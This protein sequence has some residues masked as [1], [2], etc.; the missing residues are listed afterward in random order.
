MQRAL[1][2]T[3]TFFALVFL[4]ASI[5][6]RPPAPVPADAPA[7]RFSATLAREM[8]TRLVGDGATRYV[9]TPGN[10]RGRAV[11]VAQL[12]DL[13]WKVEVQEA[14]SCTYHGNCAP[15]TNVVAQ[16]TGREPSLPGVLLTA[17]Y[18][19]VPTSPGA[20]DD[21]FGTAALL[22]TA[23][24]LAAGPRPRRTIV[25]A[26][27][28]GEEA[29]LLGAEAFTRGHPLAHT[30]GATVN[31]D[32]RGSG[33]PSQVFE[34]SPGNAWLVSLMSAHIDRPVTSSLFYEV[35]K[36]MPNDTDFSLTKTLA[37]GLNFANVRGIENYHTP[38]DA[39]DSSDIG[40][41]QHHGDQ[42]LAMT[43][44]FVD[45]DLRDAAAGASG[46]AVWFDVLAL[47]IVRWPE[48]WSIVLALVGLMLV[49]GHAIRQR[50]FDRGL[51]VFFA[52]IV[53][54][55]L[56]P[57][58]VRLGLG[59]VGAVPAP[60]IA[61]PLPA[62]VALHTSAAAA[63]LGVGY[64]VARR[65][66][67]Q[68]VWAGTWIGWGLLGVVA[69]AFAPGT[70]YVFVVPTLIAGLGAAL[71]LAIA[72]VAPAMAAS[73]VL[74]F[75]LVIYDALGLTFA[76]LLVL[77]TL[78]LC[79]TLAP[80]VVDLLKR[81][82]TRVLAALGAVALSLGV[83]AILVPKF[84]AA[85]PQR[86]NV[87]FRQDDRTARVFLDNTWKR[88]TWGRPPAPMVD[89]IGG[90]MQTASALPWTLPSRFA[91]APR[92]ELKAPTADVL[93]VE[94]DGRRH[95]VRIRVRSPRGA[96]TLA[97][98]FPHGRDVAVTVAGRRADLRP[99]ESGRSVGLLAVPGEGVLVE[100]ESPVGGPIA[101]SILDCSPG[102]PA[103]TMADAAV[104][105]RPK[106]ATQFQEGDLTVVATDL[107]L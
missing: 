40:T 41:L 12:E 21:G 47:G 16:L 93:S 36:R 46:D 22:E 85:V 15:V 3:L 103:G 74:T 44:A 86:V 7:L 89:A 69:S 34:T 57:F 54:G 39:V 33:G 70:S 99:V 45:S 48:R 1:A 64:L 98:V 26:F 65:A 18:D 72:C 9:G 102:V 58:V 31:I 104:H 81:S 24:A 32:S 83:V 56:V 5:R 8:Q 60:W 95:H 59:A 75:A 88:S 23:R 55:A 6:Y 52:S 38:L 13:G 87:I 79:T 14:R 97:L 82:G 4:L 77:P 62:L 53:P 106:E 94:D 42:V 66:R 43:R 100:L 107:S 96:S 105:A 11:I 20:S 68:A 73:V 101:M 49:I 10:V 63:A 91:D 35:Y 84:S 29:G 30:V 80:L 17:H 27:T 51:F 71:G 78:L 25:A 28:D 76:P 2:F 37:P 67:P 50:A 92:I 61:Y 90:G 19:S